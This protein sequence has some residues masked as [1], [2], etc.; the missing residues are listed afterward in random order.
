MKGQK[1]E[2]GTLRKLI[3]IFITSIFKINKGIITFILCL[4]DKRS[5]C[6]DSI[7]QEGVREKFIQ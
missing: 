1:E 3:E 4:I 6:L 5:K 7:Q 2:G